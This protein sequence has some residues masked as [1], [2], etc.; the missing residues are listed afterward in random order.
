M[1]V[2]TETLENRRLRVI[3]EL[4]EEQT[5]K[6]MHKA[7]R[8]ISKQFKIPGFRKGKA[9]YDV[10][11]R[12]FGEETIR[13]E[14]ADNLLKQTYENV[15]KQENITPYAPGQLEEIEYNPITY[16][17][18]V[19]QTPVV[20][21]GDYRDYRREPPAVKIHDAELQEALEEIRDD[22]VILEPVGRPAEMGDEVVVNVETSTVFGKLLSRETD[23]NLVMDS[24]N[25]A[26][27]PGLVEAIEGMSSGEKRKVNL[28]LPDDFHDEKLRG[29]PVSLFVK[30]K[31]VYE[32][33]LPDID[34][35]LARTVGKYANL[36][37]LKDELRERLRRD[38]Q[39]EVEARYIDQV[40]M[41]LFEISTIA[42]PPEMLEEELDEAV[43]EFEKT[44]KRQTK[45][46]L[47]DYLRIK[48][49]SMEELREEIKP[50]VTERLRRSLM[51]SEIMSQEGLSVSPEEIDARIEEIGAQFKSKADKVRA[52]FRTE[53]KRDEVRRALLTGKTISRVVAIAK[54]EAPPLEP[55]DGQEQQDNSQAE[56]ET[57]DD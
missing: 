37:E 49:L 46:S 41:D 7:V 44:I 12:R 52:Q 39:E 21:L 9:P 19:S 3:V 23:I 18:T 5:Q 16:V 27:L 10:I 17:F 56:G 4:D 33:T 30:I 38:A 14:I 34:D 24:E 45:L 13:Q 35:D 15:I 25:S 32:R 50:D 47:E 36:E 51:L 11:I 40:L 55:A 42:F 57:S 8:R 28:T 22:H 2:T 20:D 53:E 1:K 29:K 43:D 48:D 54:G 6:E 26:Q 31:T